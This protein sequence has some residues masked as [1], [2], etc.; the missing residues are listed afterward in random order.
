MV[1]AK[2]IAGLSCKIW[3]LKRRLAAIEQRVADELD[4]DRKLRDWMQERT[5]LERQAPQA[6]I[7]AKELLERRESRRGKLAELAGR[8]AQL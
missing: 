3:S 1:T 5:R 2:K 4:F 8:V 7:D 6:L